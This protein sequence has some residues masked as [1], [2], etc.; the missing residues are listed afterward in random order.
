M[1][2]DS[3][4][5]ASVEIGLDGMMRVERTTSG[6]LFHTN[7]YVDSDLSCLNRGRPAASSLKR[8]EKIKDFL[9]RG[10]QFELHDFIEISRSTDSGPDN[11]LWRTGGKPTSARTLAT[12]VVHQPSSGEGLLYL[13]LANP[14]REVREYRLRL[15]DVFSGDAPLAGADN[16]IATV[17]LTP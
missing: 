5:I 12:W 16:H 7:H 17:D 8:H 2:S 1:L 15:K 14:N 3:T 9:S 10:E 11:S 13:K 6:V 4:E